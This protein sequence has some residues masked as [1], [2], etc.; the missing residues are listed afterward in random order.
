MDRVCVCVF[1]SMDGWVVVKLATKCQDP[2]LGEGMD[3]DGREVEP[4]WGRRLLCA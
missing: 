3:W 4:A 2:Y 1:C